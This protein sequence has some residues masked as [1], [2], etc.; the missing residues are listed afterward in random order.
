MI[1]N[2]CWQRWPCLRIGLSIMVMMVTTFFWEVYESTLSKTTGLYGNGSKF[3]PELAWTIRFVASSLRRFVA[4][5]LARLLP[6]QCPCRETVRWVPWRG[7]VLWMTQWWPPRWTNTLLTR[8]IPW[9][10][11]LHLA[12]FPEFPEF[13]SAYLQDYFIGD[14]VFSLNLSLRLTWDVF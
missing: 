7:V 11:W 5:S 3:S 2:D 12:E 6:F 14:E 9:K 13:M 8:W 1:V 10:I 4:S